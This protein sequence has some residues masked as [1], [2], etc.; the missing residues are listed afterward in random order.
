MTVSL[1]LSVDTSG[2][3]IYGQTMNGMVRYVGER[4]LLCFLVFEI[5][6]QGWY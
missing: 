2:R 1:C 4:L 5:S 3:E 6:S